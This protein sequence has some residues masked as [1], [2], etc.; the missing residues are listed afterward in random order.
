[1][2][3][4][5]VAT[6]GEEVLGVYTTKEVATARCN[7]WIYNAVEKRAW[8]SHDGARQRHYRLERNGSR[9]TV[10]VTACEVKL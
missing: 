2:R 1:V 10:K 6:D 9:A 5:Y 8:H 4:V 3:T 7:E